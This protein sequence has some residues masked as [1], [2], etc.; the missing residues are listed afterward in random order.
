MSI[1]VSAM[2]GCEGSDHQATQAQDSSHEASSLPSL[3]LAAMHMSASD[4]CATDSGQTL[5]QASGLPSTASPA[6]P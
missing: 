2:P 1:L 6:T 3:A 5:T 4:K